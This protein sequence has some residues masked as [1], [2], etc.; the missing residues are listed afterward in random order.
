[1]IAVLAP[2]GTL[3]LYT[4]PNII[5]KVH[6][7][8]VLSNIPSHLNTTTFG[9]SF[10]RRS[11]LLPTAQTEA[12][13]E[14]E[15]HLLSPVHPLQPQF[16]S[17][18]S[19]FCGGLRDVAANRLTLTYPDGKMYRISIPLISECPFVTKCLHTMKQVLKKDLAITVSRSALAL[20]S[21]GDR[22]S[23]IEIPSILSVD[24]QMVRCTKRARR[25]RSEC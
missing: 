1:M 13:F 9:P 20:T 18:A 24:I 10:P 23:T 3:T 8:G 14:D 25:T 17:R 6:I 7:A 21:R 16:A 15:L 5:G 2:C 12:K 22:I 19:N 4:G 11:S